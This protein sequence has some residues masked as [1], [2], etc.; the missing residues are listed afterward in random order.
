M[1]CNRAVA[2]DVEREMVI[3]VLINLQ[4]KRREAN[5]KTDTLA[6]HMTRHADVQNQSNK[7]EP[8]IGITP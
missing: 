2:V 1:F 7:T 4:E 3:H 6:H 5:I 8:T